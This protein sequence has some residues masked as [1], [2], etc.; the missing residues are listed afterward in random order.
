[1]GRAVKISDPPVDLIGS[2]INFDNGVI[3]SPIISKSTAPTATACGGRER[4]R[5][6]FCEQPNQTVPVAIPIRRV[7]CAAGHIL[8]SVAGG[9]HGFGFRI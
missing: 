3:D 1:M 8:H 6:P 4:E 7:V 9:P 5:T 2:P